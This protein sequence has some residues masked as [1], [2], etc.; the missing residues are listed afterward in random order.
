MSII[1]FDTARP[2]IAGIMGTRAERLSRETD[3]NAARGSIVAQIALAAC[4]AGG[5]QADITDATSNGY[6]ISAD[7]SLLLLQLEVLPQAYADGSAPGPYANDNTA[8]NALFS[9]AGLAN[10]GADVLSGEATSDVD[11]SSGNRTT[12]GNGSVTGLGAD[13]V[14]GTILNLSAGVIEADSAVT[15]DYGSLAANGSSILTDVDLS[16]LGT[17]LTVDANAAPNT[18]LFDALGIQ[19]VLNEQ[20]IGGNGIDGRSL[21]VNAIRISFDD[22]AAGLGLL[23]GDIKIAHAYSEMNAVVPAPSGLAALAVTGLVATRRRR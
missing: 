22:V 6:G 5:A 14:L 11:A 23:N 2:F 4:I 10:V 13:V 19:V 21:E 18:V 9:A 7:L 16:I 15:G 1:S 3:M 20:I 8:V 12:T 17:T